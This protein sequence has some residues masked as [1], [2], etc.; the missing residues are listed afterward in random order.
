M[1]RE[2]ANETLLERILGNVMAACLL[3]SMIAAPIIFAY[4]FFEFSLAIKLALEADACARREPWNYEQCWAP[5]MW[6]YKETPDASHDQ[7]R[8]RK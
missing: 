4:L 5:A 1:R 2:F 7:E 6:D 3:V 8:G